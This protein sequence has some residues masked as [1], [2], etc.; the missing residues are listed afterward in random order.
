MSAKHLISIG[1]L[2]RAVGQ[3]VQVEERYHGFGE[4]DFKLKFLDPDPNVGSSRTEEVYFDTS[5]GNCYKLFVVRDSSK[6]PYK[7]FFICSLS[8]SEP[9]RLSDTDIKKGELVVGRPFE[10]SDK[11]Y[12]TSMVHGILAVNITR[13]YSEEYF[14]YFKLVSDIRKQFE[15]MR[16]S[17]ERPK[18][19]KQ[20]ILEFVQKLGYGEKT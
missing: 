6:R 17:G 20:R 2:D 7:Q 4:K 15:S 1:D 16:A 12:N 13:G 9:Q 3:E 10:Y 11:K 18:P 14:T 19:V 8:G 5:S